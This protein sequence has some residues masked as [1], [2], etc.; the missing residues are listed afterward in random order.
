MIAECPNARPLY[1]SACSW[2]SRKTDR[3][4]PWGAMRYENGVIHKNPVVVDY[5]SCDVN[6]KRFEVSFL[7]SAKGWLPGHALRQD[8]YARLPETVG[9]VRTWKHR[10]PPII[11]DKR[12]ILEPFMFHICP[13]NSQHPGYYS[14][15]LVDAL[16]AKAIPIYWGCPDVGK[17]FNP[18]GIVQ[19][20]DYNDLITSLQRL[21]PDFYNDRKTAIEENHKLALQ[22][23]HQWDQIEDYITEGIL[24]KRGV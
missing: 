6:A 23:A 8:I 5:K 2:M 15:K 24:K 4:D 7:T 18:E 11:D 16:V 9:S 14:E 17:Y 20:N 13:E 3:V 10:S 19:F 22:G 21:T 1:E 12:T